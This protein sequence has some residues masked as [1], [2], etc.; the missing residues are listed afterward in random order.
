MNDK[1]NNK[2]TNDIANGILTEIV[3]AI[4]AEAVVVTKAKTKDERS[5]LAFDLAVVVKGIVSEDGYT[6]AKNGHSATYATKGA[7]RDGMRKVWSDGMR[8]VAR[9]IVSDHGGTM[10]PREFAKSGSRY[11]NTYSKVR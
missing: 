11:L 4:K 7:L 1:T 10:S 8:P 5:S 9:M 3:K 6:I 2:A